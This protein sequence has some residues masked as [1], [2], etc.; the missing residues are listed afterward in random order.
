MSNYQSKHKANSNS[1]SSYGKSELQNAHQNV[2]INEFNN[3]LKMNLKE[4]NSM[5]KQMVRLQISAE[6]SE[7]SK[8]KT[9][10]DLHSSRK[11]LR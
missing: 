6:R 8:S 3:S 5:K 10:R 11:K 4:F 7:R 1:N 9:E 2:H